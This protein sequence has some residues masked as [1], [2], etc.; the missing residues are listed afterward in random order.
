[1]ALFYPPGPDARSAAELAARVHADPVAV[2]RLLEELEDLG[3]LELED[4]GGFDGRRA[5]LTFEGYELLYEAEAALL[6][7]T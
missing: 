6:S 5:W 2:A 3:Y 7:S 4:R 1:V